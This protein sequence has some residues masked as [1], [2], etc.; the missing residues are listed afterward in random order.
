MRK[1]PAS[2]DPLRREVAARADPLILARICGVRGRV[3]AKQ[4]RG[5]TD[6]MLV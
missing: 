6:A 2:A 4:G 3:F 5:A 1:A